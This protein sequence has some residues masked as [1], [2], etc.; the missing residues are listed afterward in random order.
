MFGQSGGTW[1]W[2]AVAGVIFT[3]GMVLMVRGWVGDRA[4]GRRR[5]PRYWYDMSRSAGLTCSECGLIAKRE[6]HLFRSRRHRWTIA[7]GALALLFGSGLTQMPKVQ[8]EGWTSVAPTAVL[9][10]ALPWSANDQS[11]AP[12][13]LCRLWSIDRRVRGGW[14]FNQ[15]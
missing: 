7:L 1:F 9:I 11:P 15:A 10:M 13:H 2:F 12:A 5:C 3:L 4:K 8:R 14:Y 6:T